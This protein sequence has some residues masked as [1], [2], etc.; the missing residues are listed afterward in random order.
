MGSAGRRPASAPWFPRTNCSAPP[1][2]FTRLTRLRRRERFPLSLPTARWSL[3]TPPWGLLFSLGRF[4]IFFLITTIFFPPPFRF[5]FPPSFLARETNWDPTLF[6]SSPSEDIKSRVPNFGLPISHHSRLGNSVA[7]FP[8]RL[9]CLPRTQ[10]CKGKEGRGE[11]EKKGHSERQRGAVSANGRMRWG[12]TLYE[13]GGPT[14][15]A[16]Y[17]INKISQHVFRRF[18]VRQSCLL[19]NMGL[20]FTSKP[21]VDDKRAR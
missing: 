7:R 17:S 20:P 12:N 16:T 13:G 2:S 8:F 6:P 1:H 14:C 5:I 3:V 19:E 21:I 4:G 18:Q 15:E 11:E 9:P 10:H